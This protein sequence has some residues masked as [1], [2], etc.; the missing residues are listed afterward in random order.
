[1]PPPPPHA[2]GSY[3]GYSPL[4]PAVTIASSIVFNCAWRYMWKYLLAQ[5]GGRGGAGA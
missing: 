5:V 4:N 1:M 3:T 2:A